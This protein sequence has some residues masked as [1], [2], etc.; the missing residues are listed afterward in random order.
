MTK[1][2]ETAVNGC[3]HA[4]KIISIVMGILTTLGV[5]IGC[6]AFILPIWTINAVGERFHS[7]AEPVE[8]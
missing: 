6:L 8:A 3:G 2:M 5:L 7:N 1:V 4:L